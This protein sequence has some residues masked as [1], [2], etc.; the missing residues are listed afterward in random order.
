MFFDKMESPEHIAYTIICTIITTIILFFIPNKS[1]FDKRFFI[2]PI[3]V[4]LTKY[5]LGDWDIGYEW[6]IYDLLFWII[7]PLISI[8]IITLLQLVSNNFY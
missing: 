5:I 1:N 2:P 6:T 4:L 8:G 3:C 7:L